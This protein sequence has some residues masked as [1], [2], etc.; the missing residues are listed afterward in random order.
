MAVLTGVLRGCGRQKYGAAANF[1]ANWIVGLALMILFAFKLH[2]GPA[3]ESGCPSDAR[4]VCKLDCSEQAACGSSTKSRR[5]CEAVKQQ[6][7]RH[8][9]AGPPWVGCVAVGL[10]S[11][12]QDLVDCEEGAQRRGACM[13]CLPS[14]PGMPIS[15]LKLQGGINATSLASRQVLGGKQSAMTTGLR[16]VASLL[17][18]RPAILLAGLRALQGSGGASASPTT[19]KSWPW[20][21]WWRDL[22]GLASR[23]GR[24]GLCGGCRRAGSQEVDK[25]IHITCAG[26]VWLPGMPR[27]AALLDILFSLYSRDLSAPM[28][29]VHFY[30]RRAI[31]VCSAPRA[32]ALALRGS[33]RLARH[34]MYD[35]RQ[36]QM[37]YA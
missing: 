17:P 4:T 30:I 10:R 20:R 31:F 6:M 26:Q 21:C 19:S 2:W 7:G 16:R 9:C 12:P 27:W 5:A 34:R 18:E 32:C 25:E 28:R 37:N 3:G 11:A 35:P 1:G 13:H 23:R 24:T 15:R 8:D 33:Y 14:V 29:L 22:T 36:W